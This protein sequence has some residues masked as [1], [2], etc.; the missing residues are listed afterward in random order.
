VIK[1]IK[2]YLKEGK[3]ANLNQIYLLGNLTRDPE[4]RYTNEGMA[5][6]EMG[7]AVNKRW[8]DA[9]GDENS[10]VDFFN[11]TVWN[12]LAENCA[13]SLKKGDRI[14]VGGHLNLRSWE[15]KDGKKY[16]IVNITADVAALS[17]EFNKANNHE[18]RTNG[19]NSYEG[20]QGRINSGAGSDKTDSE[21][22]WPDRANSSNE[23]DGA[24]NSIRPD[25]TNG[26]EYTPNRV[27][28][29]ESTL[30]RAN[31]VV[32]GPDKMDSGGSRQYGKNK[33]K[34][35]EKKNNSVSIAQDLAADYSLE[36]TSK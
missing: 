21:E 25:R 29:S 26:N 2:H 4:L 10:V 3:L 17:L 8:K 15:N 9:N 30:D 36:V 24:N 27:N 35:P 32:T 22:S 13:G 14:M 1:I 28:G 31:R 7:L 23:F 18:S 34:E 6:A 12:H 20:R 5:I 33:R 11:I 16:N 19:A